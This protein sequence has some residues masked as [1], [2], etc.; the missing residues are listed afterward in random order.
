MAL[1]LGAAML[2][3]FE[4]P[5]N[6]TKGEPIQPLAPEE[7]EERLRKYYLSKGLK[8]FNIDGKIV[9]ARN[10]TNAERKAKNQSK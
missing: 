5:F 8:E 10:Q 7:R 4:R 2:S 9:W 3:G 6:D 1:G